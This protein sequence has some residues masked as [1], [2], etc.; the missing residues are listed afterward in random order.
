MGPDRPSPLEEAL[1]DPLPGVKKQ[2]AQEYEYLPDEAIDE[3]AKQAV[4]ELAE[5][6]VREFVP[7]IAWRR[8]RKR[9]R[10]AS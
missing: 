8:A 3:A 9:L 6:R 2:L 5:A 7:V 1:K 10:R 4:D